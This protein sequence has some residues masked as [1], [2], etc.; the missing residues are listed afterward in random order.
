MKKDDAIV[1]RRRGRPPMSERIER[2]TRIMVLLAFGMGPKQVSGQLQCH[3]RTVARVQRDCAADI[4]AMQS[5]AS[6]NLRKRLMASAWL[7]SNNIDA[8]IGSVKVSDPQT[9]MQVAAGI[10]TLCAAAQ[11][12]ES[13][14]SPPP[15]PDKPEDSAEDITAATLEL[16]NMR[17]TA[18]ALPADDDDDGGGNDG[19]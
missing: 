5:R 17:K 9:F 11:S 15:P 16:K 3:Y 19:G 4:M 1:V 18:G 6:H 7:A 12:M 10:K 2:D 14:G 8:G 13:G